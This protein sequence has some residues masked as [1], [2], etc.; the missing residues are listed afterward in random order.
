[1][2]EFNRISYDNISNKEMLIGETTL[3]AFS[4]PPF[5]EWFDL[6]YNY[7]EP[8]KN[9]IK[10]LKEKIDYV[11]ILIFLGTWC[12]DSRID[13][14]RFIKVLNEIG[15]DKDNLRIISIDREKKDP[16]DLS[17]TYSIE[18]VPTF[19]FFK[20]KIELGRIIES[21]K[22]SLETDMLEI[23]SK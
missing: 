14:P 19:V 8:D 1:M 22:V 16:N 10:Q 20:D 7:Y 9:I 23:L 21:P 6:E 5:K 18:Y 4:L 13:V 2:D 15:F 11:K 3:D 12:P 17:T